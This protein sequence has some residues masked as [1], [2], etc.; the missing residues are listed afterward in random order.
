VRRAVLSAA[1]AV[2][3]APLV[4]HAQEAPAPVQAPATTPAVPA[5]AGRDLTLEQALAAARKANRQLVA[6]RAQLAGVQTN[7]E[8]AWSA[9]FPVITAQGKYTRNYKEADLDF[10]SLFQALNVP[11]S[12]PPGT[13]FKTVILRG[14]QLDASVNASMPLLAP[15][16]YYGLDAVKKNVGSAEANYTASEDNILLSVAQTFYLCAAADE[17]V[18]SRQT[19]IQVATATLDNAKTRFAAGTVTKVDVD[20]AELAVVRA[21]QGLRDALYA[22]QQSYRGLSTLIQAESPFT[23]RPPE[24]PTGTPEGTLDTALKLRPEFRALNLTA[25]SADATAKAYG[26]KWSPVLSAFGNARIGNYVGFTGDKYA[27]AVGLQLDWTIFDGGTR[28]AQRHQAAW[29]QAQADAQSLVL[30]DQIRD[31]LDN[32]KQLL[33]TRRDALAASIRALA[34]SQE[35]L[36]LVRAQYEAGTITQVDLLQAQDNLVLAQEAVA[37]SRFDVATADVNLRYSAG[38]FPGK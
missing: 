32:G 2:S 1:L 29:A 12:P 20:R 10:L 13:S 33:A 38:T 9:L 5:P 36:E 37:R 6:N 23:V 21:D 7:I 19:D 31:D 22:R 11:T 18:V 34:L 14:N 3:L 25:A 4:A 8:Q 27:W 24:L 30:A 15:A 28:D 35:T 26:W 17:V 16:A